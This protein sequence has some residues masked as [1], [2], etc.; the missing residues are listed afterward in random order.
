[1]IV[2]AHMEGFNAVFRLDA[3]SVGGHHEGRSAHEIEVAAR[4]VHDVLA[5]VVDVEFA[6]N[7]DAFFNFLFVGAVDDG[8]SEMGRHGDF[9]D[10]D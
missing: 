7:E 2:A 1:M 8:V 9:V 5:A 10:A 4:V 6:L 3:I